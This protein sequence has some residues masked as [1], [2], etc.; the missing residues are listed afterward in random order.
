MRSVS[1][2]PTDYRRGRGA[3][4]I[5]APAC[6]KRRAGQRNSDESNACPD[7]AVMRDSREPVSPRPRP[8]IRSC[9]S[10]SA[11]VSGTGLEDCYRLTRHDCTATA[12]RSCYLRL[13]RLPLGRTGSSLE[14]GSSAPPRRAATALVGRPAWTGRWAATR[15]AAIDKFRGAFHPSP[16]GLTHRQSAS[17][18]RLPPGGPSGA[19]SASRPSRR[20]L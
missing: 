18:E 20:A 1:V 15:R 12:D 7:V 14:S 5:G 2:T 8:T 19:H 13:N 16:A 9:S 11:S 17:D 3:V 4:S 10:K 6:R